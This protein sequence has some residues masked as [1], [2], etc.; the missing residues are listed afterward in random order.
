MVPGPEHHGVVR[1]G[2]TVAGLLRDQQVEV[3]VVRGLEQPAGP[4]DVTHV[5]FTDALFG[6]DVGAAADAFVAWA[7][8]AARPLVVTLHD[9]PGADADPLRDARRRLGYARVLASADAAVVSSE[10]EATG[11]RLAHHLHPVVIPLPVEPLALPG[12]R[13]AWAAT[14]TVGVLG[15]LYPGKGHAEAL[16]CVAQVA[17]VTHRPARVVAIGAVSPGHEPLLHDLYR[18]A[19]GL[20]VELHVTGPLS[21][22]DLHAAAHAVTVPL[23]A[24]RTIGASASLTTWLAAG[25]RAVAT[26]SAY[27]RE[28][29][30]RWPNSL[31]LPTGGLDQ[32]VA[33]A[34][35]HPWT[36]WLD[37]TPARPDV[38]RAHLELF[39]RL[40]VPA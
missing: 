13:P 37:K 25:R 18:Q 2:L 4:V 28:L 27:A 21:E 34:L 19:D 15:F 35:E 5:Q 6:P 29:Q 12:P 26:D 36:T 38:G 16:E 7:A 24:Y 9:V 10:H 33:G 8:T 31:L 17:R 40:L 30:T 39:D 23:A 1:H 20:G 3:T 11:A 22:A 14:P 32:A